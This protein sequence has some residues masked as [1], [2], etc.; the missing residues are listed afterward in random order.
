MLTY[1]LFHIMYFC[2]NWQKLPKEKIIYLEKI[3][4]I[5][6]P[7]LFVWVG[8]YIAKCQRMYMREAGYDFK[9]IFFIQNNG[10]FDSMCLNILSTIHQFIFSKYRQRFPEIKSYL[11]RKT[12][13]GKF[14]SSTDL[15][16]SKR[17]RQS[18]QIYLGTTYQNS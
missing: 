17:Y 16:Q 2:S 10:E 12:A 15:R 8:I 1:I 14:Y 7:W 5:W 3:R 13:K 18:C 4:P 6:S 9:C 11:N